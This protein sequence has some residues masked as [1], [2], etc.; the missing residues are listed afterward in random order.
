M[1]YNFVCTI[2]MS[3]AFFTTWWAHLPRFL[4][5]DIWRRAKSC[6]SASVTLSVLLAEVSSTS[7][8]QI[9]TGHF[10]CC[11]GRPVL[12]SEI[13]WKSASLYITKKRS[14]AFFSCRGN[15]YVIYY[16]NFHVYLTSIYYNSL[17][18][19]TCNIS[20]FC[21]VDNTFWPWWISMAQTSLSLS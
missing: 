12:T 3:H 11:S 1:R 4:L 19:D 6:P 15:L 7:C 13:L 10:V 2:C 20:W 17:V 8:S 5:Q 16:S 21:R 9:P 14:M 18:N